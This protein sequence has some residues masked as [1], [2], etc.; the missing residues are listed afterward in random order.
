MNFMGPADTFRSFIGTSVKTQ[1][2]MT[3][4]DPEKLSGTLDLDTKYD[5]F[6]LRKVNFLKNLE[7]Y[8]SPCC[9]R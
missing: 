3:D 9:F 2:L 6:P 5:E 8:Y 7:I 4:D 1:A